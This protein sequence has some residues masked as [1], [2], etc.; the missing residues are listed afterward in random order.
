MEVNS[1]AGTSP[2][3]GVTARTPV[4]PSTKPQ[5][6]DS[7]SFQGADAVNSALQQ[8][9]DVRPEAVTRARTLITNSQYPTESVIQSIS[10]LFAARLNLDES[11]P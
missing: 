2:V 4:T 10:R 5:G 3:Q 1:N 7:A 6:S 9:P 11:Q 8:I